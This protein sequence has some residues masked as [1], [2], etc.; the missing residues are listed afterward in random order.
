LPKRSRTLFKFSNGPDE[1]RCYLRLRER[2]G[3][4]V[5]ENALLSPA[6]CRAVDLQ[7][8]RAS[9]V[10]HVLVEREGQDGVRWWA[11]E[12]SG[13]G[14]AP[15]NLASGEK[16]DVA[17]AL[18]SRPGIVAV[19]GAR[20]VATDDEFDALAVLLRP[21]EPA[22]PRPL[23]YVAPGNPEMHL[24]GEHARDCT[25]AADGTLVLVGWARGKHDDVIK[26]R[27]R[28][29]VIE[30]DVDA[31]ET[32][33]TVAGPG[34][35]VQSRALAVDIDDEGN[36]QLAGTTCLDVCEPETEIRVY[37]PGG[38]LKHKISLGPLGSDLFGPHDLAW[39]P[40][41]Y[42]VVALGGFQ[43]PFSLFKVQAFVPGAP[44]PA[45]T[46]IAN[47]KQGIQLALAVAVGP[48]GEVY[49]GGNGGAFAVIGG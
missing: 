16:G 12:I 37:A 22:D 40:A 45:W 29:A 25:F 15:M 7:V 3:E 13:W 18:A 30:H 20:P 35:G 1:P 17:F 36:Y 26:D 5:E 47:D 19:C 6:R 33:W 42:A 31:D 46:F 27:D 2:T 10:M 28:I 34:P 23:D 11:G 8:D 38:A 48:L 44:E 9:G 43:G 21:D 49:A 14:A 41:G 32:V 4:L 39:S 24:F